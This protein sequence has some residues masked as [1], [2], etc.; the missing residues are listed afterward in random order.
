MMKTYDVEHAAIFPANWKVN[1]MLANSFC[2]GT[3]DD[4]K[5]ILQRAM[6]KTDGQTLDVDM[7]L[8]CLQETLDFEQ[9]LERRFS[10]EVCGLFRNITILLTRP[11]SLLY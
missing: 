10:N 2:E 1:E 4:F 11:V 5:G 8:S 9:S 6:R 3:R 7:M